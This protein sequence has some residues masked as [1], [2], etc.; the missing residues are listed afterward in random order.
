MVIKKGRISRP[1]DLASP[2]VF[3]CNVFTERNEKKKNKNE[4]KKKKK[5]LNSFASVLVSLVYW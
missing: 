4:K 3:F 2:S 5:R 1:Y